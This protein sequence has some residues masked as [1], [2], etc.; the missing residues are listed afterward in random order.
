MT[1]ETLPSAP[2]AGE[3]E[4]TA[5]TPHIYYEDKD[6]SALR[7]GD[8]PGM[9]SGYYNAG[10][11]RHLINGQDR[12]FESGSPKPELASAEDKDRDRKILEV[13]RDLGETA[14]EGSSGFIKIKRS[15]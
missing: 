4:S 9:V 13:E 2:P 11:A 5:Q 15:D 14:V 10:E 12:S 3:P 8:Q 7:G 6:A 1:F